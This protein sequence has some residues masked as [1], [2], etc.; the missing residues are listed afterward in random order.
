MPVVLPMFV[1]LPS[2]VPTPLT[3]HQAGPSPRDESDLPRS[4]TLEITADDLVLRSNNCPQ[5]PKDT[6]SEHS[7][8]KRLRSVPEA[9]APPPTETRS[10]RPACVVLELGPEE[11][12][13]LTAVEIWAGEGRGTSTGST[14]LAPPGDAASSTSLP[15]STLAAAALP[16]LDVPAGPE[17]ENSLPPVW[18]CCRPLCSPRHRLR[19]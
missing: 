2:L 1:N 8:A 5:D 14:P 17:E 9:V 16:A 11:T 15:C 13:D 3:L 19:W 4:G 6:T 18:P 10:K 7:R 12:I